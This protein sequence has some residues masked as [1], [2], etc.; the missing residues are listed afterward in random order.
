MAAE[1][2]VKMRVAIFFF[3]PEVGVDHLGK[4]TNR[5]LSLFPEHLGDWGL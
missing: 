5:N 3:S 1:V 4:S 2:L